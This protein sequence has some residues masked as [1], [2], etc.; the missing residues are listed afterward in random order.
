V[1]NATV[2]KLF[3][4]QARTDPKK[5]GMSGLSTFLVP[6]E[7]AGL[8]VRE[9]HKALPLA[10]RNLALR[11]TAD[12]YELAIAASLANGHAA[13]ACAL[14]DRALELPTALPALQL[15]AHRAYSA[16]ARTAKAAQALAAAGGR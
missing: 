3:A 10:E 11:Q 14:A 1:A 2:A 9:P 16:C 6:R 12:A 7:T 4:V 8:T 15:T 13:R 5:T